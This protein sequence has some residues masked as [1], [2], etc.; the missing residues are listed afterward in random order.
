MP[1]ISSRVS[2]CS[3]A[4]SRPTAPL[5]L[6]HSKGQTPSKPGSWQAQIAGCRQRRWKPVGPTLCKQHHLP[7]ELSLTLGRGAGHGIISHLSV[8]GADGSAD[9]HAGA[10]RHVRRGRHQGRGVALLLQGVWRAD[11]AIGAVQLDAGGKRLP[12]QISL[13]KIATGLSP[14]TASAARPELRCSTHHLLQRGAKAAEHGLAAQAGGG[15]RRGCSRGAG[16]AQR[17]Q[18]CRRDIT[19]ACRFP[20]SCGSMHHPFTRACEP[21]GCWPQLR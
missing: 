9:G 5:V 20:F 11:L 21:A 1:I 16:A 8:R 17:L 18:K 13:R 3:K 4:A 19:Q 2:S 15:G 6:R 14:Q 10:G 12:I 7:P